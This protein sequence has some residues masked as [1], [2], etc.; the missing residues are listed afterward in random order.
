M[1]V[2]KKSQESNNQL[3]GATMLTLSN[4]S[5]RMGIRQQEGAAAIDRT[6]VYGRRKI[7]DIFCTARDGRCMLHERC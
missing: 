1:P 4:A 7:V 2:D 3:T 6:I 5:I